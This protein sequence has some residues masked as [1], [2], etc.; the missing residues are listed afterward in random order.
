MSE[1]VS[2][3][4]FAGITSSAG[5][6]NYLGSLFEAEITSISPPL[7]SSSTALN[8]LQVLMHY[9]PSLPVSSLPP[10]SSTNVSDLANSLSNIHWSL[11]QY[12]AIPKKQSSFDN[13]LHSS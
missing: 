13:W 8:F 10:S 6:D 11:N 4:I 9:F 5:M 7:I 12:L 3:R 1:H 2:E